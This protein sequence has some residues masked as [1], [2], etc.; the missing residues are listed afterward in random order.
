M[1]QKYVIIALCAALIIGSAAFLTAGQDDPAVKRLEEFGP[2]VLSLIAFDKDQ[3]EIARGSAVVLDK[4]LAL[5]NYHL[6]SG[7][8]SVTATNSKLKKVSVE[9]LV[10]VDKGLDLAL[11]RIKGKATPLV[12][13]PDALNKGRKFV[14]VGA[15]ESGEIVVGSGDIRETRELGGGIS[16]GEAS[17]GVPETFAGAAVLSEDGKFIGLLTIM[18]HR[19]RFVVPAVA[20]ASLNRT[21]AVQDFKSLTPE[22]YL[23]TVEGAWLAG[24]LYNWMD[25]SLNAQRNLEKVTKAQP[26][27]LAAW[28]MLSSVYNKQR[29]Y[30][31]AVVAFKKVIEFDAQNAAAHL[32]LGEVLFR[33]QKPME[34]APYLEKA[35]VLDPSKKEA[36]MFLGNAYQDAR[37]WAKA[38]DAYEKYLA[39]NPANAWTIYKNIGDCRFETKEFE[40]SAAAFGEALKSQPDDQ[41]LAYRQARSYEQAGQY[42]QA[43]AAYVKLATMSP[44]DAYNYYRGILAM[45]DKANL[46]AKAAAAGQKL[47]EINPRDPEAYYNLGFMYQKL[48]NYAEAIAQFRKAIEVMPANGNAW[49]QVGY[50]YYMQKNYVEAAKA[51][52]KNVEII[53]D[54]FYGYLYIGMSLMQIKQYTA[55]MDPTKKAVDLKPDDPTALYNL[56]IIYLNLRDQYSAR[57]IVNKLK[58][59]DSNLANKLRSYIK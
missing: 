17:A 34:A 9:G 51:F 23:G 40:K 12:P 21:G 55:A 1:K 33:M 32:G 6:I 45:Y 7:A 46:P 4:D 25:E 36:L 10:A 43:E 35:L 54:S 14:A 2:G 58:P 24:R 41:S 3:K 49:F 16:I 57:D 44:K 37:E 52:Q 56:G 13:A 20:F 27:N 26:G 39:F 29:D 19:L 5:T 42:E 11:I 47:I 28:T 50:C 31:N 30:A 59:I 22:A 48:Q 15:N 53:S 38:A 18:D 8:A